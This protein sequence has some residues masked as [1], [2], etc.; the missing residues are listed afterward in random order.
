MN[1]PGNE[2]LQS[3]VDI[4]RIIH[5][6]ARLLILA[7]L[8]VVDKSDYLFLM[9]QTGLTQGNL[10]SHISK[11]EQAGYIKVEKEFQD[12]KPRTLLSLTQ[13][14]KQAFQQYRD[15]MQQILDSLPT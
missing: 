13:S 1:D 9:R 12:K 4:D 7:Y 11:L 15:K 2:A 5:E 3:V 6:P 14:G 8:S 10:S